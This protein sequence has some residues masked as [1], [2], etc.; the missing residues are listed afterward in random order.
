MRRLRFAAACLVVVCG[1]LL[2]N[3]SVARAYGNDALYQLTYSANCNNPS[4]PLCAPD[5][6]GLGG[7]WGWIEID[8]A[9]GDTSG[10]ADAALT[11]CHHQTAG[12]VNGATHVNLE[13]T[14]WV[15]L[16]GKDLPPAAFPV[17]FPGNPDE[18][19]IYVPAA[20]LA[21]PDESDHYSVR[22]APG[23]FVQSTVVELR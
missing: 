20:M 12:Q 10:T 2:T 17:D 23:V 8:G 5:V 15:E 18:T 6:F 11:I 21:F 22:V 1:L 7:G 19:Y 3:Q 4:V 9:P 16:L 13:D 14:P